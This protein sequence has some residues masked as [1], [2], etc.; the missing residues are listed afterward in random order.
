MAMPV[1]QEHRNRD[2][3]VLGTLEKKWKLQPEC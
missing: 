1:L 2:T 3:K